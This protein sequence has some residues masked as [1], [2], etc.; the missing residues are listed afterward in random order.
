MDT[1]IVYPRLWLD[2]KFAGAATALET[3][4]LF[5]YLINCESLKLSRYHRLTDR[6][7]MF[8]TGLTKEQLRTAKD[9]LTEL[10]WCFFKDSWIYHNH[11]C[12][13]IS[14]TGQPK[15]IAA[16]EK[17]IAEV[18]QRIRDYF[19]PLI[20]RSERILNYKLKTINHR[21]ETI[22]NKPV[23]DLEVDPDEADKAIE[24]QIRAKN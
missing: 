18:P 13:Y 10:K 12:A 1:R 2:E 6:Q 3:K 16:K 14:Y 9:E 24:A 4:V 8:D 21:T 7:I 11:D 23:D 19:N 20:T 17:Q 5:S 22:N 15:V